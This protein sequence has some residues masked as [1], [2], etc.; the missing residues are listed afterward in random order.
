M[1]NEAEARMWRELQNDLAATRRRADAYERALRAV[2]PNVLER[3]AGELQATPA[4]APTLPEVDH[5]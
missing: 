4:P 1:M 5:G 2:A 3:I